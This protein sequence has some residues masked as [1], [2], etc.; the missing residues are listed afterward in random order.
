MR[1]L[2]DL[3]RP[4]GVLLVCL[5][6]T[7]MYRF[8]IMMEEILQPSSFVTALVWKSRRNL[9]SRSKHNVSIDHEYVLAFKMNGGR[10]RGATKDVTKYANPDNDPRGPRMSDNLVGLATKDRRLNLHYDLVNPETGI[11]YKC[12]EKGWRCSQETMAQKIEEGRIMWPKTPQGRPRH[13]K[14]LSDLQSEFAGFS[15]ILE[16]GNTNEGTEEVQAI[17][18]TAG[19]IFP[20]PRSLI[21]QLVAQVV[22]ES[23]DIVLD[24]FAGSGTTAHAVLAMNAEV[25]ATSPSRLGE[26]RGGDAASTREA[27]STA[28]PLI[29]VHRGTAIY[30]LCNGILKDK[31]VG[32]GNV[33]TWAVLES[34]PRHDG[35][36]IIY[37]T[38][39]RISP[40]RRARENIV[41]KQIPYAIRTL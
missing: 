6:D 39:C 2:V 33:L 37:G 25:D 1:L 27:A 22:C 7:E 34:L 15:S 17:L 13:K 18:G 31:T 8:K 9:D 10:F 21:Q 35:S 26:E 19:F 3:L 41:F 28:S 40:A 4:D 14:F 20:K 16:C 24:S 12:P 32:G 11:I 5:D 29:G 23:G 36:K 38:A 30:L